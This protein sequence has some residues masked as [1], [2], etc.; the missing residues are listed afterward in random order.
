MLFP[1]LVLALSVD[2]AVFALDVSNVSESGGGVDEL[3]N[4]E[5]DSAVLPSSP[6]DETANDESGNESDDD[7][8]TDSTDSDES[9]I[10]FDESATGSNTASPKIAIRAINPGY[11]LPAGNNSGELI[12][13]VNLSD[14]ELD[15]SGVS[16]VYTSKPT[17]ASPAGKT[18]ALY[19]FPKGASFIG[20]AIL[21][22][23]AASP[24]AVE[25]AQDLTYDAASLAMYGALRLVAPSGSADLNSATDE[26][27]EISIDGESASYI[28]VDSV[29]WLGGE[30]CLPYFSTSVKSRSYTTI[31]RDDETGEYSHVSEYPSLYNP[32]KSGLYLPPE[33]EYEDEEDGSGSETGDSDGDYESDDESLEGAATSGSSTTSSASSSTKSSAKS[34][35]G[36][37]TGGSTSSTLTPVC[38]G[39][40]FS[41]ILTYYSEEKSEQF[42]EFY[43]SSSS[44]IPISECRLRYKNKIYS[45]VATST[46]SAATSETVLL[47]P[48]SYFVFYPTISLTKNPTTS[49][50]Y[51]ILDV[52]D[53]VVDSLELPHGQKK[54]TSFAMTGKAEDGSNLWQITYTPTPGQ[55]NVYQ[56]FQTCPAGKIIN[57][58]TGNCVNAATME[59]T[60][61]DCPA[62]KYRN[63]ATGR[64]KSYETDDDSELTPCAEG[65]ERN[66]ETNRCRKIK[67]NNGADYP[68]VPITDTEENTSFV[69]IWALAGV[70]ALGAGY[71]IFQFR[72]DIY[73]ALRRI[74]SKLFGK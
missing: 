22:R 4:L 63:P 14:E 59:T 62:G 67:E 36:S 19:T 16:L 45:L 7:S 41:E 61:A 32:E 40:E 34:G 46:S 44:S 72:R 53:A 47:S 39:L 57:T 52:N 56:E 21:F 1:L 38:A 74:G 6:D 66:P 2:G 48:G 49:N 31:F 65:Y 68:L 28:V 69:A 26:L 43:N 58:L 42:I 13:L 55:P 35:T 12:E 23:Y 5:E 3:L 29:C 11:N 33:N 60:L 25:G 73:Y 20:D 10:D 71:I 51:E 27:I 30:E 54:S 64:C 24:E 17:A 18:T 15:L 70:L 9:V 50:L 8:D 37:S